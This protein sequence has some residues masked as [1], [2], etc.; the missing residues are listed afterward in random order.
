MMA[1]SMRY[2]A[3]WSSGHLVDRSLK[4]GSENWMNIGCAVEC[5]SNLG[6]FA[7]GSLL[8]LS[9]IQQTTPH[10]SS[11]GGTLNRAPS[12]FLACHCQ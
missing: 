12:A 4:I 8:A 5:S 2:T 11:Q 3:G 6:S 10:E 1:L 7:G 9:Y